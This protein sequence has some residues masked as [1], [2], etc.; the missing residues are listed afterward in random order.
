MI[1]SAIAIAMTV[2]NATVIT[3]SITITIIT[4]ILL[5]QLLL[6]ILLL[7]PLLVVLRLLSLL[8]L[9]LL[10]QQRIFLLGNFLSWFLVPDQIAL[11]PAGFSSIS[12]QIDVNLPQ[13]D[14]NRGAW[15]R[16]NSIPLK[17][18]SISSRLNSIWGP[19]PQMELTS[20]RLNSISPTRFPENLCCNP[21]S[22]GV[23]FNPPGLNSTPPLQPST[24]NQDSPKSF[25]A[26][27]VLG[28]RGGV[29]FNAGGLNSTSGG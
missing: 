3:F 16:L 12:L 21:G 13:I 24:K 28:C 29:E 22:K 10:N 4:A 9:L 23:E 27:L 1:A 25:V 11:Y 8:L 17:L 20:R 6:L 15:P 19:A 14:F 26:I 2:I 18:N 5:L 7:L